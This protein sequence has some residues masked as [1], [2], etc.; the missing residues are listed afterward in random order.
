MKDGR[1]VDF[2]PMKLRQCSR[3]YDINFDSSR[4]RGNT[5]SYMTIL[6]AS[7]S[8]LSPKMMLYNFGSTLYWLKMARMVT[9]SV[10]DNVDPNARHSHKPRSRDSSPKRE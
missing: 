5:H 7:F 1:Q 8:R 3:D 2:R 4:G 9:G 10:A 6:T